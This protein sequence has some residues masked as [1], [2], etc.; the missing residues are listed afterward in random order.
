MKIKLLLLFFIVSFSGIDC[1]AQ[2]NNVFAFY[3]YKIKEGKTDHFT[4]GYKR[5]LEWHAE[6]QDPWSWAGWFVMNGDRRGYFI[7]ATPNHQWED[8]DHWPIDAQEN[9]KYNAIHW[10][11]YVE[12][13]TGSF[14][15]V[16]DEYSSYTPDWFKANMLQTFYLELWPGQETNFQTLL[17][18]LGEVLETE[19]PETSFVWMKTVSGGPGQYVLFVSF[20]SNAELKLLEQLLEPAINEF[21]GSEDVK[22][23]KE[24]VKNIE[25]E[26]WMYSDYLSLYPE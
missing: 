12:K 11:S 16:L 19:F 2:E 3:E 1:L 18:R 9:A 26:L 25:H 20:N 4:E 7:D 24:S 6:K 17:G 14:R 5:D 8:F 21:L 10:A 13:P 15:V 22:K 23:F